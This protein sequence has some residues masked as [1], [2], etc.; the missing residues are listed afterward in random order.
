MLELTPE[1]NTSLI[2]IRIYSDDPNE[3]ARIAEAVAETY[4]QYRQGTVRR[5]T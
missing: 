4:K 5:R 1:R 3:A 2:D